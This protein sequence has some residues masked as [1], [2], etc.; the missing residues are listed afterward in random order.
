[1]IKIESNQ[2]W[3]NQITI[4][5]IFFLL[6]FP[7]SLFPY[8]YGYGF[9]F[10]RFTMHV[11]FHLLFYIVYG[12]GY[13][14]S[15]MHFLSFVLYVCKFLFYLSNIGFNVLNHLIPKSIEV[16]KLETNIREGNI[17]FMTPKFLY[18][19]TYNFLSNASIL[20]HHS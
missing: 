20:M 14:I 8:V 19:K 16:S 5:I 10:T 3:N 9:P 2:T 13:H 18:P 15:L 1:M 17:H 12:Y 4:S 6:P 7:F 11:H